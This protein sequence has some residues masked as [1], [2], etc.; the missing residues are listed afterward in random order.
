M[1]PT[2]DREPG[3][4]ALPRLATVLVFCDA[5][6][7]GEGVLLLNVWDVKSSKGGDGEPVT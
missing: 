4:I 2:H 6:I 3:S 7:G 1:W 5:A